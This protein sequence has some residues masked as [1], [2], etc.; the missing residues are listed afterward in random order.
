MVSV[1]G[2]EPAACVQFVGPTGKAMVLLVEVMA[3]LAGPK[4]TQVVP[5]SGDHWS[6]AVTVGEVRFPSL[7]GHLTG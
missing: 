1:A 5:A 3:V 6:C 7:S 2:D 4:F